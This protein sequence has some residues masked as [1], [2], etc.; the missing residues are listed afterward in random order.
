MKNLLIALAITSCLN[1]QVLASDSSVTKNEQLT[2]EYIDYKINQFTEKYSAATPTVKNSWSNALK[3]LYL[4]SSGIFI[5]SMTLGKMILGDW[6][7]CKNAK[8]LG[9]LS[10][11]LGTYVAGIVLLIDSTTLKHQSYIKSLDEKLS[12]AKFALDAESMFTKKEPR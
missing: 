8:G 3:A 12:N 2:A 10:L 6:P 1:Q 9:V 4:T 7:C 11:T 5:G